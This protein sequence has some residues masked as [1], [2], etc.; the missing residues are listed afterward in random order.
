MVFEIWIF[1]QKRKEKKVDFIVIKTTI[2][3]SFQNF[4]KK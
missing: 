1:F 3:K 4:V 2:F